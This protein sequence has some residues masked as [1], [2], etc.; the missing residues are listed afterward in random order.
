MGVENTSYKVLL[1]LP[2]FQ[3]MTANELH[4]IVAC[5]PFHFHKYAEKEVIAH[6]GESCNH[7]TFLLKGVLNVTSYALNRSY[8]ITENIMAPAVLPLEELYGLSPRYTSTYE[9]ST[10]CSLLSIQ[11]DSVNKLMEMSFIF[12]LNY[13]NMLSTLAQKQKRFIW[14]QKTKN[15]TESML[16]F[17]TQHMRKPV[18]EKHIF[19]TM[20]TLGLVLNT[21]RIEIS[22]MLKRLQEQGF[23]SLGRGKIYFPA[24]EKA[25]QEAI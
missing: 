10:A 22:K 21:H 3:G 5:I 6:E 14:Q 24:F 12:R 1:Q 2:L 8:A 7:L 25:L 20:T 9:T 15:L 17:F 13:L 4:D 19:I 18:G 16:L 23:I 11:K